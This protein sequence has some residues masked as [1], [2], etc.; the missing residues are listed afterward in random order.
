MRR[1]IFETL[2]FHFYNMAK[3]HPFIQFEN[4]FT[5]HFVLFFWKLLLVVFLSLFQPTEKKIHVFGMQT[6]KAGNFTV[7]VINFR[8]SSYFLM[9]N[10]KRTNKKGFL[11][12]LTASHSTPLHTHFWL[13]CYRNI[14]L[15]DT[16]RSQFRFI[17]PLFTIFTMHS[18]IFHHER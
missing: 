8:F 6:S 3:V 5:S 1:P 4:C 14:E 13:I 15:N 17:F 11:F 9:S 10:H 12:P 7:C 16:V 2:N 18:I